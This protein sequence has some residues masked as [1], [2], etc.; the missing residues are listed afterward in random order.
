MHEMQETHTQSLEDSPEGEMAAHSSMLA[1]RV[2]WTGEPAG[3]SPWSHKDL[4]TTEHSAHVIRTMIG[5]SID[6]CHE[7]SRSLQR[8]LNRASKPTRSEILIRPFLNR[9]IALNICVAF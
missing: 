4:D 5:Q 3:C 9:C 6:V 7:H 8:G 2:S 1:W